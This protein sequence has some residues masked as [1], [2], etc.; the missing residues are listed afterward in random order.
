MGVAV[1]QCGGID[2]CVFCFFFLGGSWAPVTGRLL[3]TV[4]VHLFRDTIVQR[5]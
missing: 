2:C 5:H 4:F 1:E 3:I